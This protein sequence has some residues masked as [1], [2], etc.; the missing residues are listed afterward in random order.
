[1]PR[2]M[3]VVTFCKYIKPAFHKVGVI[4]F[5]PDRAIINFGNVQNTG[6][7]ADT[8]TILYSAVMVENPSTTNGN[9][10]W[11]SAGAEFDSENYLWV[12]QAPV[13]ADYDLVW[14]TL[15]SLLFCFNL[16]LVCSRLYKILPCKMQMIIFKS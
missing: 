9:S 10:Y 13:T 6:G 8:I 14:F 15:S 5:Q 16:K 1:M 2:L 7:S 12:G 4:Y 11:I 3:R